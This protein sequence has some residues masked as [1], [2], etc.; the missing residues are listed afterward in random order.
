MG[1]ISFSSQRLS[2]SQESTG[3]GATSSRAPTVDFSYPGFG[4]CWLECI[5]FDVTVVDGCAEGR[6][7]ALALLGAAQSGGCGGKAVYLHQTG[8]PA[9]D[10]IAI[11]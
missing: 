5:E 8:D 11:E 9:V 6:V 7:V 10:R 3:T 4:G 2:D 1:T